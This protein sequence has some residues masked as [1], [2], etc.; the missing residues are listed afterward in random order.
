MRG[1][2]LLAAILAMAA[3]P[4]FADEWWLFSRTRGTLSFIDLASVDPATAGMPT[5]WIRRFEP[6]TPRSLR[7]EQVFE[8]AEHWQADCAGRRARVLRAQLFDRDGRMIAEGEGTGAW[9]PPTLGTN[10][11]LLLTVVCDN[12]RRE[13]D[14]VTAANAA[15]LKALV[16]SGASIP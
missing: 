7:G 8:F 5:V 3:T 6:D 10:T 4:A 12:D 15:A 14:R 11:E 13:L 9:I 2:I 16:I 1:A